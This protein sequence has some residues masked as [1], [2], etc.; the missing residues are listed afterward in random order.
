MYIK[1]TSNCLWLCKDNPRHAPCTFNQYGLMNRKILKPDW[2][3]KPISSR[4]AQF[5]CLSSLSFFLSFFLAFFLSFFG[6]FILFIHLFNRILFLVIPEQN[7]KRSKH[8]CPVQAGNVKVFFVLNIVM[9][10]VHK[11]VLKNYWSM[12]LVTQTPFF[13]EYMSLNA[14]KLILQK[15]HFDNDSLNPW[16]GEPGHDPLAKFRHIVSTL[17][18]SFRSALAPNCT[19]GLDEATCTFH[20]VCRFRAF[21]QNK[22]DKYHLKLYAVS[23]ADSG[24]CL[25]FEVSTGAE[26]WDKT[27]KK[28]EWEGVLPLIQKWYDVPHTSML[29]FGKCPMPGA[30]QKMTFISE[31]VMQMMHKF[32]LLDQ[33]HHLYTD[34]FYSSL[35]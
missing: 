16:P 21:N 1:D 15:L 9:G 2:V 25:G 22:P 13:G 30:P 32:C 26:R 20:S 19:L 18:N 6:Y 7:S 4:N 27:T 12:H 23:E 31:T 8:W 33:G 5:Y 24:Y 10:L 28:L 3:R 35:H 11:P 14:F 29:K 17:Q 34:N